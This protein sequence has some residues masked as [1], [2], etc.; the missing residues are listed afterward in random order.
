M[1]SHCSSAPS[2][3][4]LV[5]LCYIGLPLALPKIAARQPAFAHHFDTLVRSFRS[6]YRGPQ[7][8]KYAVFVS[9]TVMKDYSKTQ[10][11]CSQ[12][13]LGCSKVKPKQL[14]PMFVRGGCTTHARVFAQELACDWT[15]E[16]CATGSATFLSICICDRRR[17]QRLSGCTNF[18]GLR[19][20]NRYS[21]WF[22]F[23]DSP[24]GDIVKPSESVL[25]DRAKSVCGSHYPLV[26][27]FCPTP[28][29]FCRAFR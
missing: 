11:L 7:V 4:L 16:G 18:G 1:S 17:C 15:V 23:G 19:F 29:C 14:E 28:P 2:G 13:K 27:E 5:S 24:V 8:F 6:S 22:N 12:Y 10:F 3:S 20:P 9:Y 26:R 21:K 25:R